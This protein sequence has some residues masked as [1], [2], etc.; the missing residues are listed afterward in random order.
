MWDHAKTSERV[1]C[2]LRKEIILYVNSNF[3]ESIISLNR[4]D[5]HQI[6]DEFLHYFENMKT[7]GHYPDIVVERF[8]NRIGTDDDQ[9]LKFNAIRLLIILNL[10]KTYLFTPNENNSEEIVRKIHTIITELEAA[11]AWRL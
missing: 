6:L 5:I 7:S 3:G 11:D 2:L 8:G 10:A 4:K 9:E 1:F